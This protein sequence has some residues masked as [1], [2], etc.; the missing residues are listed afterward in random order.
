LNS[1]ANV[2]LPAHSTTRSGDSAKSGEYP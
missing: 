1:G 2:L